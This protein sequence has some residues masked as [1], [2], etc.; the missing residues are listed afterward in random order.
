MTTPATRSLATVLRRALEPTDGV[1]LMV[2]EYDDPPAD[3][4]YAS[5]IID[6]QTLDIPKPPA[7]TTG[8]AAYVLAAPGRML[9]LGTATGTG[10]PG[11][12]GPQGPTGPQGAKGDTGPQ[13]PQGVSGASTFMAKAGVPTATDG[14]NGTIYL[15]LASLR[16]WGPKAAGAWPASA[17]GRVVPLQPTYDQLKTG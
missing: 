16:F 12:Q 14:A 4:R 9:V 10:T 17:F 8:R 3:P 13:G 5:V 2:G 7:E 11:P 6:G 15:D 1:R